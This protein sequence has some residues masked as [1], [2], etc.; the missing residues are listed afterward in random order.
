MK[1]KLAFIDH[2]YHKK[3]RSSVFFEELLARKYEIIRFWDQSWCGGPAVELDGLLRMDFEKYV[4]WQVLY[5]A[6]LLKVFPPNKVILLPMYDQVHFR[7][8]DF[9]IQYRDFTFICFCRQLHELLIALDINSHYIQFFPKPHSPKE[10]LDQ[11]ITGFFWSRISA[12][13]WDLIKKLTGQCLYDAFYLHDAP[14]V[15]P[16]I[17]IRPNREDQVLFNIQISEWFPSQQDLVRIMEQANVYFAPRLFE[18]IG[19]SFLEAMSMGM[20]VVSPN[21]PTMNEYIVS[22]QTGI[23]YDVNDLRPLDFLNVRDIGK[24]AYDLIVKGRKKWQQESEKL[25]DD[26]MNQGFFDK[27]SRPDLHSTESITEI[28]ASF[29]EIP[30]NARLALYGAGKAGR[31]FRRNID[32]LRPDVRV[33]CYLDTFKTGKFD[34]LD[35]VPFYQAHGNTLHWDHIYV[36]SIYNKDISRVLRKMKIVHHVVADTLFR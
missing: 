13:Q 17:T 26:L 22:G 2:S 25:L 15:D 21:N 8:E 16:G 5:D 34:G 29:A 4:F 33:V 1:P 14:D 24:Q 6:D 35:I 11:G 20:C 28:I 31:K 18:G 9:W 10:K 27:R 23:L 3:T 36:T 32:V 19:F 12:I 7:R 30:Q